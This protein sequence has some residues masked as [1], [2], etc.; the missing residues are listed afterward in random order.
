MTFQ[1]VNFYEHQA[2]PAPPPIPRK[3]AEVR[4]EADILQEANIK[5]KR[6]RK[7]CQGSHITVTVAAPAPIHPLESD[8]DRGGARHSSLL[9]RLKPRR[10][11]RAIAPIPLL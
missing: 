6:R 4:S 7:G 11:S 3:P 2:P 8:H 5:N 1:F 10:L 9:E